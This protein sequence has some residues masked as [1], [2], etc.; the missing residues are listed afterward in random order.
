MNP[1]GLKAKKALVDPYAE[2]ALTDAAENQRVIQEQQR[3]EK[4]KKGA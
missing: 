2:I 1:I 4:E 3:L